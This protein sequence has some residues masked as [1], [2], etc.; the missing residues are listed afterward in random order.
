M[1]YLTLT[2]LND[3]IP[4]NIYFHIK[5]SSL[6]NLL[7]DLKQ[8][9]LSFT[10]EYDIGVLLEKDNEVITSFIYDDCNNDFKTYLIKE[11]ETTTQ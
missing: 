6:Q 10:N 1:Y 8:L 4:D 3:N 9:D 5:S 7:E 11:I 2:L